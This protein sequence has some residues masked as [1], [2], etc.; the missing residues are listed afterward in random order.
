MKK[1]LMIFL[2]PILV[3]CSHQHD[4]MKLIIMN[5]IK[6]NIPAYWTYDTIAFS[7]VEQAMSEVTDTKQYQDIY[8]ELCQADSLCIADSIVCSELGMKVTQDLKRKR[9]QIVAK[10]K[11]IKNS[12]R[13]HT[14]GKKVT[15]AYVCGTD[16]GD[17]LYITTFVLDEK[18]N[19][20]KRE[21]YAI[22]ISK[23]ERDSLKLSSVRKNMGKLANNIN[24]GLF[25]N[26]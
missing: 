18:N 22:P 11:S 24:N 10:L 17:S 26:Y 2:L 21:P 1:I 9:N 19:I 7:G 16:F 20:I 14:I 25:T 5:E 6:A 13:P 15:H 4:N 12:Y 8:K 23:Q 3:S